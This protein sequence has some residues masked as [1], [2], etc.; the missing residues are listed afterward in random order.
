MQRE[1]IT[2]TSDDRACAGWFYAPDQPA[3]ATVVMAH[4]LAGVK[5]MRL[6]AYAERF[7]SAGYNV[8]VFDYRH[9]GASDGTPRQLLD[10]GKQRRDWVS[11][12]AYVRGRPDVDGATIALWGTSLSGGHVLAV[13]NEVGSAAVISQV[14]HTD[15][16]VSTL[17]VGPAQILRLSWHALRDVAGSLT[18]RPPHYVPATGAPGDAA[19]MTAGD[20]A[21]RYLGLVPVDHRFDQRVAARS[22][23]D[24]ALYSPGRHLKRLKVPVLV[25]V[26]ARDRITPAGATLRHASRSS[27]AVVRTYEV[28]HFEPYTGDLFETFV[29]EQIAFL[30]KIFSRR[31]ISA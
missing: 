7:A 4:G 22:I 20:A 13:A 27:T 2:F 26:G 1:N 28:G 23:L 5:E 8:L 30:D 14:P 31:E 11:A 24:I 17:A 12:V 15:G 16:P 29:A 19:M 3:T 6:D 25:Q 9:F 10:L 21:E 18:G